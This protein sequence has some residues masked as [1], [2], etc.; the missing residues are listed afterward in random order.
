VVTEVIGL[1]TAG[2]DRGTSDAEGWTGEAISID[3]AA[4]GVFTLALERG[5]LDS[6]AEFCSEVMEQLGF[7]LAH[8]G[9][10]TVSGV[11]S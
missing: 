4:L 8:A 1:T 10:E 3:A 6:A 2:A 11:A 9:D 5:A 7:R